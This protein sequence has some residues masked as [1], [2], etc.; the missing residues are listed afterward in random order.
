MPK[1]LI[2]E[3]DNNLCQ[4]LEQSLKADHHSV[5]I[6]HDG[7]DAL[8]R[9]R[10]YVYDLV[11]LDWDIPC[12]D[13]IEVCK[14]FRAKGGNAPILMLT[15][16]SN[17]EEK[18]HGFD[19]G[20]DDYLTKPFQIRELKSRIKALLR[21]PA[22]LHGSTLRAAEL[23]LDVAKFEVTKAGQSITL[24]PK[25]FALLE[26]LMR[27]SRQVDRKSTRLNSS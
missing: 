27:H 6:S 21:R 18:E 4:I 19:S 25:E 15:G 11:V 7:P 26:F 22:A 16:K 1:I 13:G 14:Q 24:S 8:G 9:L 10:S 17:I 12:L 3:D 20:V 2:V 5:E 23:I